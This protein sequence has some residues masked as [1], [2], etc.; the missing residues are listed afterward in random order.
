MSHQHERPFAG[1]A[2][3]HRRHAVNDTDVFPQGLGGFAARGTV[4]DRCEDGVR[5]IGD[6][7]VGDVVGGVVAAVVAVD[8]AQDGWG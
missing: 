3:R 1:L 8:G 2:S 7:L 6:E 4:P 5:A